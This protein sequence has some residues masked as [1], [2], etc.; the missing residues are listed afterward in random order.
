M[1]TQTRV[2]AE[3]GDGARL[4]I[5]YDDVTLYLTAVRCVNPTGRTVNVTLVQLS[6]GRTRSRAF[7]AGTTALSI[8]TGAAQRIAMQLGT[9]DK[10]DGVNW[11]I[12]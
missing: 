12:W 3:T 11:S 5:D 6:N 8:G 4:E 7:G 2:L 1:A 10:L 9:A